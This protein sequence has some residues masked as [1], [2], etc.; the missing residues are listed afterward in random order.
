MRSRLLL[1]LLLLIASVPVLGQWG[2]AFEQLRIAELH[3]RLTDEHQ[4]ADAAFV[5]AELVPMTAGTS[6]LHDQTVIV[7]GGRIETI[8]PRASTPLPEGLRQIDARGKFLFP[9]LTDTH[10]HTLSSTGDYLLDLLYGVT[11]VREMDGFPWLLRLR[12]EARANRIL[13]P[14]TY[15]AGTILNGAP[16][17]WY[18]VVVTS[19]AQARQVVHEQK[20]AGY[21]YIKVHNMMPL[22]LYDAIIAAAD[23]EHIRVVG[24]IPHEVSVA[25]A[26]E[27]HQYTVEH[28]KGFLLDSTL[29]MSPENWLAAVRGADVWISPTLTNRRGGMTAEETAQFLKTPDAQLLS[30]RARATWVEQMGGHDADS[31]R[32]VWALSQTI[33]RQLLPVT[34]RFI[35]GTDS[36]GGYPNSIRGFALH[37]ELETYE[38]M[39]MSPVAALRTATVNAATALGDPASFG[40]IELGKRADL[41]LLDG[42]PLESVR[43]LRAPRGVMVRGIWLDAAALKTIG[44]GVRSIYATTGSDATL[45]EPTPTQVTAM[46]E[47]VEALAQRRW[48]FN[49]HQLELLVSALKEKGRAEEAGRIAA[50]AASENQTLVRSPAPSPANR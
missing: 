22:P 24:H 20:A 30:Q 38:S 37:D 42:N 34:S 28:F 5:G 19:A 44:D 26:L 11:T 13:A 1:L 49:T 40:S 18:A 15:V 43:N 16:M 2:R 41:L 14:T 33:F 46:V 10:V 25:H 29:T 47:G 48:V 27:S 31:S 50:I 36:G 6:L 21:D 8:G 4:P 35:A 45:D 32:K 3:A 9:G 23:E 12:A 17:G 39:G 7:R